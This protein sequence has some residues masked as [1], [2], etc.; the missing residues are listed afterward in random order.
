METK[1]GS[2]RHLLEERRSERSRLRGATTEVFSSDSL[3]L[4]D[5]ARRSG[6][7]GPLR[8]PLQA[9]VASVAW[10]PPSDGRVAPPDRTQKLVW[11]VAALHALGEEGPGRAGDDP[12]GGAPAESVGNL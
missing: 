5:A 12:S 9:E 10:P 2:P 1:E 3:L 6:F 8:V 11:L 7:R 4:R